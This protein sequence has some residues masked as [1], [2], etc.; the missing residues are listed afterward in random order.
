MFTCASLSALGLFEVKV[1]G[2]I[3]YDLAVPLFFCCVRDM[4]HRR[5]ISNK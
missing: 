4:N 5:G 1:T 2:V 3:T